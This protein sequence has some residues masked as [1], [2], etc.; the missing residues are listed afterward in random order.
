MKKIS[1]KRILHVVGAMNTAGTETMLMNIYRNIA[2]DKV[3]FDFISYSRKDADYDSE[4]MNMGGR[5]IKLHNT[6]SVKEIY[7]V[8]KKYGPYDVVHSHT[9]FHCG[10]AVF[11]AK[12]A[13]VRIR[14][15][16]AHTTLD[17]SDS[18]LRRIYI[19]LMRC[20]INT[21]ST[22][23]L[24]C[25]H[26][27]GRYLFGEKKLGKSKYTSFPNLIDYK[28]FLTE[29]TMEVRKFKSEEGLN[30]SIVIGHVG[31]FI[32]AK[33]HSFL[34][35]VLK[36]LKKKNLNT[37]LLLVGDG[38]L[39]NEIKETAKKMGID[40][41]IRFVGMRN[42][43]PRIL[44]SMDVFVFPSVHEGLGLVLLEAQACGLPC[45]VSEAIQPEADLNINLVSRLSLTDSPDVWADTILELVGKKE[46]DINKIIKG[47]EVNGYSL[48]TGIIRL[49]GIYNIPVE[50]I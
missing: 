43:I 20:L 47:F 12:L 41:D 22:N 46:K 30:N 16:H 34:L 14:I 50:G 6:Q 40:H 37:K 1:P 8:I 49:L 24:A 25:S 18:I 13:G 5:V 23:L 9:L 48:Q 28:Q 15:A 44:H 7:D 27:A 36:S 10:I 3:Q 33:N 31:R 29:R 38:D 19:K 45:V 2:R 21:F 42:D 35:A 4:I 26:E 39:K 32:W 11:A 17:K